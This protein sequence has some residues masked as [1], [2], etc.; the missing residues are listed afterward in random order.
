MGALRGLDWKEGRTRAAA[1]MEAVG[2]GHAV[3]KKIKQIVQ[4]HGAVRAGA[5]L[6]R[7]R[8]PN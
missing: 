8:S 5:G 2:L 4:R 6:Y 7:P 3:P 1:M